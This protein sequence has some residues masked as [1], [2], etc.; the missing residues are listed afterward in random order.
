[1]TAGKRI[2]ELEGEVAAL[3]AAAQST[4]TAAAPMSWWQRLFNG[5]RTR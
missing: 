3:R 5:S 1:M 4:S 2:A